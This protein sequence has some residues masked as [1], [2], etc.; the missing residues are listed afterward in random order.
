MM[1]EDWEIG[2]LYWNCLERANGD[3]AVEKVRAKYWNAFVESGDYD[4]TLVLG[5]TLQHHNK[6]A[7]NPYV[8]KRNLARCFKDCGVVNSRSVFWPRTMRLTEY[9]HQQLETLLRPGDVVLDA[10]AGNGHDTLAMARR[11]GPEGCVV[12]IDRQA[13]AIEATRQRLVDNGCGDCCEL[14][15][16]DH[17][18]QLAMLAPRYAGRIRAITFNLGY[19]PGGDKT[20]TTSSSS[21]RTAL[22]AA[23][24]LLAEDGCLFVTAYR[25][26]PGGMDEAAA[27]ADWMHRQ[28]SNAWTVE[29]IDAE[30]IPPER[31]PPILWIAQKPNE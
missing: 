30:G 27:V 11:V 22:D 15:T 8:S 20:I 5:T 4:L 6:R 14:I 24:Q 21:T 18:A 7:P 10:T 23:A 19:L 25:G 29:R 16:G 12:A 3:E 1:I 13:E 17:A 31:L 2:A 9:V 28:A 26:H